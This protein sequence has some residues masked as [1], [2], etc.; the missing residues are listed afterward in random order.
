MWEFVPFSGG[1]RICPAVVQV[2]THFIYVIVRLMREF[3]G[4]EDRDEVGRGYVEEFRVSSE[5]RYGVQ[6]AFTR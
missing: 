1:P 2:E 3:A 5:S 6:V 4:I